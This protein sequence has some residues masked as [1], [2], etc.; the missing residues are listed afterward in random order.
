MTFDELKK[1]YLVDIVDRKKL[2]LEERFEL[3]NLFS[4]IKE[5]GHLKKFAAGLE[6]MFED[7]PEHLR[8]GHASEVSKEFARSLKEHLEANA[9]APEESK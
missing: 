5:E 6:T 2:T 4:N 3:T 8:S 9:N 7:K 1:S